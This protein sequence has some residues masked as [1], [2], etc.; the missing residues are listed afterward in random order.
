MS[1]LDLMIDQ[2]ATARTIVED[3]AQVIPSWRISTP[4]G[5][6]L[7]LTRFDPDKPEQRERALLLISRF[8][9]WKL[10]TSFVL[11]AETS[12][13]SG[14]T[15]SD[16]E[17]LLVIGVS[18]HE[19]LGLLQR[20]TGRDPPSFGTPI[21]LMPDQV[22]ETYVHLLPTGVSDIAVQE[23]A[24]LSAIFGKDGEMAAERLD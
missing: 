17:A 9:T 7:V 3:G 19:R 4:E 20:I 1:L 24:E 21:W 6:Y 22:D 18:R 13:G 15:H 12:L 14:A 8:M 10:A 11:T 2:I 16:E 23:I 5:N